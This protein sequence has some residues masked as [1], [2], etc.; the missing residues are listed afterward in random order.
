MMVMPAP[1]NSR[2]MMPSGPYSSS[3][4]NP[5][6]A[7]GI[8]IGRST[9]EWRTAFSGKSC[10]TS[11]KATAVPITTLIDVVITAMMRV[12]FSEN[13]ASGEEILL[14]NT[15][16]PLLEAYWNIEA[17]GKTTNTARNVP[18]TLMMANLPRLSLRAVRL[19]CARR[20]ARLTRNISV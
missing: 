13:S 19:K 11:M 3:S 14:Q 18:P 4:V 1:S 16:R 8:A 5:V 20:D 2:P 7:A 17:S 6:T 12:N 10:R 9:R 15:A